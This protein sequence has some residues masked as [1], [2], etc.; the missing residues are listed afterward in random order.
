MK[1][2]QILLVL[3]V[4]AFADAT[5]A[6]HAHDQTKTHNHGAAEANSAK[7]SLAPSAATFIPN[8]EVMDQN[9]RRLRFYNDLVKGR[10]V[11]INFIY[12][13]C[14]SICPMS[15]RNFSRLQ[16]LLGDRLGRDVHLISVSTDPA[17]DSPARLKTW[18]GSFN[19]KAGWTL[20][21]GSRKEMTQLL[22][23]L[24]GDGPKTGYHVVSI[25]AIN[26]LKGNQRRI[27]GLEA[28]EQLLRLTDELAH[29]PAFKQ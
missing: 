1:R 14:T 12:T 20:V 24:T 21:T 9:G 3:C 19:P 10:V 16:G 4:L 5:M 6:Q 23:V 26:D 15:G 7:N 27:Y 11:I 18:S 22:Q 29:L 28:P 8:V 2:F 13:T 17:T 25:A